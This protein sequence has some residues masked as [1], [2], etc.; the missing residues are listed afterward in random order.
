MPPKQFPYPIGIGIDVCKPLRILRIMQDHRKLNAWL[1]KVFNRLEWPFLVSQFKNAEDGSGGPDLKNIN[2]SLV[3]T[4][5]WIPRADSEAPPLTDK[6]AQ[7]LAG[8]FEPHPLARTTCS[9][10]RCLLPVL[11][12]RRRKQ[13]W[14]R[15]AIVSWASKK[16]QS[17]IQI[18]LHLRLSMASDSAWTP[19]SILP[20]E[21]FKWIIGWR[22]WGD[23]GVFEEIKRNPGQWLTS[24]AI[25]N[26]SSAR[27]K[28]MES[29]MG[30]VD[31]QCVSHSSHDDHW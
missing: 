8:R 25:W 16:Y 21:W 28:V 22:P 30:G 5:S 11:D 31:Y 26:P 13:W 9:P 14:R 18:S 12:G 6:L 20:L 15:T 29:R 1:R 17:L 3:L 7:H 19:S 2:H 27:K 4:H 24:R 23:Y 10:L